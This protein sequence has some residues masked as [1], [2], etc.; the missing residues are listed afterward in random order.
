MLLAHIST[1]SMTFIVITSTLY[2]LTSKSNERF[3]IL[4]YSIIL[5]VQAITDVSTTV[6]IYILL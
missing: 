5:F 6:I 1:F 3:A 2:H 4:Q